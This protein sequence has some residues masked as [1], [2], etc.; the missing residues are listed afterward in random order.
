MRFAH[1]SVEFIAEVLDGPGDNDLTVSAL[2]CVRYMTDHTNDRKQLALDYGLLAATIKR[3]QAIPASTQHHATSPVP[4]EEESLLSQRP[5]NYVQT[6][7]TIPCDNLRQIFRFLPLIMIRCAA[8]ACK[9]VFYDVLASDKELLQ[10]A[11]GR[12]VHRQEVRTCAYHIIGNVVSG[13]NEQSEQALRL[14]CVPVLEEL[15]LAM[16]DDTSRKDLLWTVSNI[17]AGEPSQI[18]CFARSELLMR[19]VHDSLY[20]A[21]H[22]NIAVQAVWAAMAAINGSTAE[23]RDVLCRHGL[24]FAFALALSQVELDEKV[25]RFVVIA[26]ESYGRSATSSS[27]NSVSSERVELMDRGAKLRGWESRDV[28]GFAMLLVRNSEEEEWEGESRPTC[29]EG[30]GGKVGD[31]TSLRHRS[32][33]EASCFFWFFMMPCIAHTCHSRDGLIRGLSNFVASVDQG[34]A[35]RFTAMV[36]AARCGGSST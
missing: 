25:T 19:F 18:A 8:F 31:A 32:V 17:T 26:L 11:Q 33:N 23:C 16:K 28:N 15:V 20:D 12:F 6:S 14:G 9:D 34:V 10:Q 13:T 24:L 4:E 29:S 5:H 22:P 27:P 30:I 1:E 2:Q 36:R 7:L 21:Q 3:V 35:A